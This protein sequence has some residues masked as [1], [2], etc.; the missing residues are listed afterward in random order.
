LSQALALRDFGHIE[1]QITIDDP[2]NHTKPFTIQLNLRLLPD[3]DVLEK[4]C[5]DEK[6]VRHLGI[7]LIK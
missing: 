3:T 2:Q 1:E 4:V 7:A 6:D 5:E